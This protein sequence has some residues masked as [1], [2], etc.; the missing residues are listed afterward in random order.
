MSNLYYLGGLGGNAY[1]V[2]DLENFLGEPMTV[3]DLP[4]HGCHYEDRV[5]SPEE[6]LDWFKDKVPAKDSFVLIAH[7][8][9]ANLAPFLAKHCPNLEKLVLLDGGYYQFDSFCSLDEDLKETKTFLAETVT[10]DLEN[11]VKEEKASAC[12]WSSNLEKALRESFVWRQG[13]YQLNVNQDSVLALISL[14]RQLEGYLALVGCPTLLIAQS[15]Q[16]LLPLKAEM[17]EQV[18]KSIFVDKTL[19]CGHSPHEEKPQETA[20]LI[21]CFLDREK[22]LRSEG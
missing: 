4:G 8:M 3:I 22:V 6:L 15:D 21:S 20:A 18:P 1:H 12:Y 19:D 7:S 13:T 2:K 9:G 11:L 17:L 16:E 14:Q 5:T 10:T